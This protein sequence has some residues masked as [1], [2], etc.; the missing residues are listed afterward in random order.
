[1]EEIKL[2]TCPFCGCN[3]YVNRLKHGYRVEGKH[4]FYC[5]LSGIRLSTY[6]QVENAVDSWNKREVK[7]YENKR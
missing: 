1:M 4:T 3:M 7:R 5:A 6:F 2:K